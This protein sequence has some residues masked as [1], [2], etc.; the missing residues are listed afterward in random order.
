MDLEN[1]NSKRIKELR[2]LIDDAN[3]YYY[4]LDNP[5]I[6]DSLYDSLY[7]ELI[8]L[9]NKFPQLKTDDSP[10]NRLGGQIAK[11]FQKITHTIPLYSLDNAF[12]LEELND[13]ISKIK[14][15]IQET[16]LQLLEKNL[17][18]AE[19]KIDGNAMALK[20]ENGVLKNAATRGDGKE[21]EDITNNAKRIKSIPLKLR[22]KDAPKRL[23]V[24][25]EAFISLKTF[26]IIN[27][28]R[29]ANK[30]QLFANPRNACSGSLR[31]LDPKVVA[32]RKLD[33]FAYQVFFPDNLNLNNE[34]KNHW[35]RLQFLKKCGF[36]INKYS[37]LINSDLELKNYCSL[38]EKK[39]ETIDFDTDGVVIKLNNIEAQNK[40]G[41][42]QKAPRWA[43]AL[44][45]PAEEV[46][47]RIKNLNFQVGR[48]GNVTPVANFNPVQ[49]SGTMVSR[50]TLHNI[51]R[52]EELNIH[53]FDSIVVRKAGEIIPE[54]VKVIPE[55]RIKGSSKILFPIYCPSCGKKLSKNKSEA[56]TKCLNKVCPS[57]QIGLFKHWISKS[58]MNIDG[59][60]NK[61]IEQLFKAKLIQS[62]P[63]LYTLNRQKLNPIERMGEKSINNLLFGIEKSKKRLWNKKLY[64]LGINHIGEVTA[65]NIAL[66]FKN[67]NVLKEASLNKSDR[68][69]NINGIGLEI[70]DSL[71]NWF[72]DEDNLKLISDLKNNNF[73]FE[74]EIS[75]E[76]NIHKMINHPF[77]N[78]K[79]VITGTIKKFKRNE[80]IERIESYGGLVKS[81]ISSGIDY[82]ISGEKA[83]GKLTKAKQLKIN[84][85]GEEEFINLLNLNE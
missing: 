4:T 46:A 7:K 57:I 61:M 38:W 64:A 79:F 27:K 48:S 62:I 74:D 50:A 71:T 36:K 60:G 11:G 78:K 2:R 84:I 44:K 85:L 14:R 35:D 51:D 17:L 56:A 58:A 70:I 33:F 82:L 30:E 54:I 13:W 42:T 25:G 12:N 31:Q 16:N 21:G 18:V 45:Y 39:R 69:S 9:E 81:S 52:F 43:I 59:L 53:E 65:K 15:V 22:L 80:L 6:K 75:D 49:L 23:E 73:I 19:L 1:I 26:G 55:L 32:R 3:Y 67:I 63:D 83:G 28:E 37:E 68:L 10:S 47:T 66:E 41:H 76:N 20:Y 5:Q 34:Y 72:S 77:Y 8:E 24:R 29:E 40:L